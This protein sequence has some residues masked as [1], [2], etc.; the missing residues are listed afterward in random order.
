MYAKKHNSGNLP[1]VMSKGHEHLT[2]LWCWFRPLIP[3][4]RKVQQKNKK[5]TLFLSVL[6]TEGCKQ[7]FCFVFCEL[8]QGWIS[9]SLSFKLNWTE[10]FDVITYFWGTYEVELM[11]KFTA[12]TYKPSVHT[13]RRTVLRIANSSFKE[14]M[15]KAV[16][17]VKSRKH[18][19]F[20]WG[21]SGQEW[22]WQQS[23]RVFAR[24]ER[25]TPCI[26]H[27]KTVNVSASF[28]CFGTHFSICLVMLNF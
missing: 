18:I 4:Q 8:V 3:F 23:G 24:W 16:R 21:G 5:Q 15:Q 14:W 17:H 2:P 12:G 25:R 1:F 9:I 7:F 6:F 26:I 27:W 13:L 22:K 20:F 11:L 10:A 19:L 28:P